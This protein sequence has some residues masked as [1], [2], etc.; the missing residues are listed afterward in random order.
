MEQFELDKK[1][2]SL[3]KQLYAISE[4]KEKFDEQELIE[5]L[6]NNFDVYKNKKQFLDDV[7]KKVMSLSYSDKLKFNE[8]KEKKDLIFFRDRYRCMLCD[9]DTKLL[10]CHHKKYINGTF[11]WEYD[12]SLLITLCE[13]CHK[14]FHNIE[15][16]LVEK[17]TKK[18]YLIGDSDFSFT[19][20]IKD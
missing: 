6:I 2:L 11:P 18:T 4:K 12:D 9:D 15:D 14:K 20:P 17:R 3:L 7:R 13:E 10:H 19:P 1:T 8:W 5:F 16:V